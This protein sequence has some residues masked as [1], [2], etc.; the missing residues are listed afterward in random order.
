MPIDLGLL[1][2]RVVVGV[3]L[4]GHGAQKLFGWFGG[5]GL[6]GFAGWLASMGLR[7]ARLW[8][9][10]G[11]LVE[12]VGGLLLTLGLFTPL[13]SLGILASML[14]AIIK[15]HWPRIWVSENGLEYPLVN[16]T[17]AFVLG[18]VGPGAY[19]LDAAWR[20]SL[21]QPV[22]FWVGLVIVILGIIVALATSAAPATQRE[23][24]RPA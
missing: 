1:I 9:V 21:P 15:V 14:M 19:S 23:A 18:L 7:P 22:S 17:V 6:D 4:A 8:A 16:A 13:G 10:L 2:L 11:G 3:L 24:A 12:F 5:P 20:T